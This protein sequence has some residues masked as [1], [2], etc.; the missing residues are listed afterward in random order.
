MIHCSLHVDN[1]P[2]FF[3]R[4]SQM[5]LAHCAFY[6]VLRMSTWR[7]IQ[8]KRGPTTGVIM[9]P[10]EGWPQPQPQTTPQHHTTTHTHTQQ[11][12]QHTT[13]RATIGTATATAT[14]ARALWLS[15]QVRL[16]RTERESRLSESYEKRALKREGGES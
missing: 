9:N 12:Q 2:S 10:F 13:Q 1:E 4:W 3:L 5:L 6:A 7:E 11:Q 8:N 14:K 16:L 15:G